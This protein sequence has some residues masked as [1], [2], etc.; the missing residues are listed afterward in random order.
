MVWHAHMLNPR[1]FLEDCMRYGLRAFWLTGMPW[2]LI[3]KAIDN[4]TFAYSVSDAAKARWQKMTGAQWDNAEDPNTKTF[5]CPACRKTQTVPWTTCGMPD[6]APEKAD[7]PQPEKQ[8]SIMGGSAEAAGPSSPSAAAGKATKE[9]EYTRRPPGLVGDGYGDGA[10]KHM[11]TT[12]NCGVIID[13]STLKVIKFVDDMK[14]LWISN[15]PMP[16]TILDTFTGKVNVSI[17]AIPKADDPTT[18]PNRLLRKGG[19]RATLLAL[20]PEPTEAGGVAAA[21]ARRRQRPTMQDVKSAI[22]SVV[23]DSDQLKT[24]DGVTDSTKKYSIG[25]QAKMAVRKML[26]HYWENFSIFALDLSGAV[27]RQGIFTEK[28][29]RVSLAFLRTYT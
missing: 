17:S 29:Y 10:F 19:C 2:A 11:C 18:F 27:L 6:T 13:N 23:G 25:A 26:S 20:F 5:P 12:R 4:E 15:V 9:S 7:A 28:M 8:D 16:G 21:V 3:D 14:Q 22:S 1:N 24:I